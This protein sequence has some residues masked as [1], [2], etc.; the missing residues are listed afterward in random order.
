MNQSGLEYEQRGPVA[1]ITIDDAPYNRMSL[2]FMDALESLVS[3][4]SGDRS[5]RAVVITAAGD[6]NFSVGMNLNE[7]IGSLGDSARV[8]DILDQRLRV[9]AAIENMD[10]PWIATL[11]GNCLGGGL[12]LPLACHFRLAA[13]EGARIGLPEMHLGSVPAWGGSARLARRIGRDRAVDLILRAKTL[14]G[15]EALTLGLVTE[16]WPN[17]ELKQRATELAQELA[18][19][20]RLAVASI[21]RCLVAGDEKTLAESLR[22]EREAFHATL[23]SPDMAEGMAAFTQKRSPVFN[24]D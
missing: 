20:P 18:D 24:K 1:V 3:T 5:I 22:D 21:L 16:V 2:A 7:L 19:M 11:F 8:D 10:K 15:P 17:T 9:L 12:E 6:R 14:S 4:I 23:G 13:A